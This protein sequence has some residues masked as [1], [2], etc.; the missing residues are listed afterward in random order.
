V[1]M[2]RRMA[3]EERF[4]GKS[5]LFVSARLASGWGAV[6]HTLK[7]T[8]GNREQQMRTVQGQN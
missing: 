2:T 6:T 1:E 3:S 7:K 4:M 8:I 5:P